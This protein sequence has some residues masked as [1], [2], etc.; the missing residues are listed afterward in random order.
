NTAIFSV[1]NGVLLR[2]LPYRQPDR[3][4]MLYE[5]IASEPAPFGFSAPDLVAFRERARS[6]ETLA[7]FRTAEFELSGIARPERISAARISASLTGVLGVAPALGRGFTDAEDAGRQPVAILSD[8]LWRHAFGA[9][10]S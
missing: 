9:D 1:V 6:Y 3:L 4:V 8:G 7:A 2:G 5:G 10:P